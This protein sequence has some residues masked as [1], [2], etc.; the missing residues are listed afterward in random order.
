MLTRRTARYI[1]PF[2]ILVSSFASGEAQE[3]AQ[4]A[5]TPFTV[6][7][8]I[9]I[10]LFHALG[11]T[12]EKIEFSP[13][14][15]YF[16]VF[17]E[18]GRLERNLV[19]DSLR[20]Y[21]RQKVEDFL[22]HSNESLAPS[23]VWVLNCFGK[24]GPVINEWRWL[25]DSSGVAFLEGGG[26]FGNKH[27]VLADLRNKRME[28]LTPENE[29]VKDF[30]IHD[31]QHYVYVLAGPEPPTHSHAEPQAAAIVG[32]GR[33]LFELLLPEN[34]RTI[35]YDSNRTYYLWAVVGGK[36]FEIK[37]NGIPIVVP[38]LGLAMSPDG[39][40]VVA[41]E[42]VSEV[43]LSWE[44]LYPSPETAYPYRIRAGRQ[45]PRSGMDS[46]RQYVQIH[47]LTGSVRA[48]ADAP[49]SSRAGWW[50]VASP[51]WSSDSQ[52]ILL[53]HTFLESKENVASRPC[54]AVVQL[55]SYKRSCIETLS[56]RIGKSLVEGHLVTDIR[57]IDGDKHRVMV[58][59]N[60]DSDHRAGKTEYRSMVTSTWQV[61]ERGSR[62]PEVGNGLQIR[63]EQAIDRPPLLV[64]SEKQASRVIWDPNPQLK[65]IE[66]GQ[67]SVYRWKDREGRD[68][69][70]VLYKPVDSKSGQRYP[71]VIQT[72]GSAESQFR[73]SGLYPTAFAAT[74][75][76]SVGI[77]VLQVDE[78][79]D[80]VT[81]N[82]DE[83]PCAVLTYEAAAKQLISEGLADP[84]R[85]GIIGFSR[86]CFYVMETLTTSTLHLKAASITD[87]VME[88][89]LQ[90]MLRVQPNPEA[91]SMIGAPPF[92]DGLQQWLKR[93]PGFNL[94]K[95]T[96]PLLVVGAGSSSLL[97]MW[98]PYAGLRYLHKPV[99]LIMLNTYDHPSLNPA[100]RM[101]SQGGSVDWFRFWLQDY[102]DPDPAKAEQY[103]RWRE[104]RKMQQ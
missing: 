50:T 59:F 102:E 28:T 47:L 1:T 73:P 17:A 93:S 44:S 97:D 26:E 75:L 25:P 7:D 40:S 27:L 12:R 87:G 36:R 88:T 32:T 81:V 79:S 95:I 92:R 84:E 3:N 71:L 31:R 34:P 46:V 48:L 29:A 100:V 53:P 24:E 69:R 37:K 74:E 35:E 103:K 64:A 104:L 65:N 61:A 80:C 78:G 16:A 82:R 42:V 41:Q 55:P 68:R 15:N 66:C 14:G 51:A 91:N 30:D 5:K 85:I 22:V 19:E 54:V 77:V 2:L 20:F 9:G 52:A 72:H 13:D 94:D 99:E 67:T 89:Y 8:D 43:P 83:G 38:A 6:A 98:E 63:V 76:S 33:T 96:A 21:R 39:Q 10:T 4:Q 11:I 60:N 62:E 70:G 90:Y 23:P 45:D 57:F 18:R 101:A 49:E 56:A 58:S 86:T